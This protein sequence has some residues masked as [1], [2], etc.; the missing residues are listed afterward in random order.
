MRKENEN[1]EVIH[2]RIPRSIGVLLRDF[3][4][5]DDRSISYVV[6]KALKK[7]FGAE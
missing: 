4:R 7:F 5:A 2:I 3:A 1:T 6:V